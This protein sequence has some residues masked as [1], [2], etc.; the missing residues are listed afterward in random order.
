[1][2]ETSLQQFHAEI[3]FQDRTQERQPQRSE[4]FVIETTGHVGNKGQQAETG[5]LSEGLVQNAIGD[6]QIT[7]TS[8]DQD[9]ASSHAE[10]VP[11]GSMPRPRCST[12][13]HETPTTSRENLRHRAGDH[14]QN[15]TRHDNQSQTITA[16]TRAASAQR[17]HCLSRFEP[18]LPGTL[19]ATAGHNEPWRH[20]CDQG[21]GHESLDF[22]VTD[23]AD[24]ELEIEDIPDSSG[25]AEYDRPLVEPVNASNL[26]RT[27]SASKTLKAQDPTTARTSENLES[28]ARQAWDSW[29]MT[30]PER[31]QT[32]REDVPHQP[33]SNSTSPLTELS[34]TST[35]ESARAG[36]PDSSQNPTVRPRGPS[37]LR[38][39]NSSFVQSQRDSR[40]ILQD[41]ESEFSKTPRKS[42]MS[43]APMRDTTSHDESSRWR[44]AN[45]GTD[46]TGWTRSSSARDTQGPLREFAC[47]ECRM[48]K[49]KCDRQRPRCE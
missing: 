17:P 12:A 9:V 22:G 13:F 5:V 34:L 14:R 49:R 20:E 16:A 40:K 42:C 15:E 29:H 25:N 43:R 36:S 27:E 10:Q 37:A 46:E 33:R 23:E 24:R 6:A 39:V 32:S 2:L 1:M 41:F 47:F 19:Q 7:A 38:L 21:N 45:R 3:I 11:D 35:E 28:I 44:P 26:A 4:N 48:K 31:D 8:P 30:D 18:T